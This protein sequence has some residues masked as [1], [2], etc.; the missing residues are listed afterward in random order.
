MSSGSTQSGIEELLKQVAAEEPKV[1]SVVE[2]KPEEKAEV[3]SVTADGEDIASILSSVE[4]EAP[5]VA[6]IASEGETDIEALLKQV[7]AEEPKVEA[8]VEAKPEEK[9]AVESVTAVGEDIASI[10]SSVEKEV[11]A[12]AATASE[13]ET[14]IEAL[15]KQ[16]AAEE[17]K[18]EAVVETK[19]E[20]KAVV[21][22]ATSGE[23]ASTNTSKEEEA[24]KTV[25]P[26]AGS[27]QSSLVKNEEQ[28]SIVQSISTKEFDISTDPDVI[29]MRARMK[30]KVQEI[31]KTYVN[32][33]TFSLSFILQMPKV[34]GRRRKV[35]QGLRTFSD[36]IE[37]EI[38]RIQAI[39]DPI[40]KAV[41][42]KSSIVFDQELLH[43]RKK[44][45]SWIRQGWRKSFLVGAWAISLIVGLSFGIPSVIRIYFPTPLRPAVS[46]EIALPEVILPEAPKKELGARSYLLLSCEESEMGKLGKIRVY[47]REGKAVAVFPANVNTMKKKVLT[48][49]PS[50]ELGVIIETEEFPILGTVELSPNQRRF[51]DL[52]KWTDVGARALARIESTPE[53]I[54]IACN[55]AWV[56]KGYATVYLIAGVHKIWAALPNFPA[57]EQQIM[58]IDDRDLELMVTVNMGR[59]IFN[60]SDQIK[61]MHPQLKIQVNGSPILNWG[62]YSLLFGYY[63]IKITDSGRTVLQQDLNL[64]AADEVVFKIQALEG[65]QLSAS[66]IS[67]RNLLKGD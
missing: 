21:E 27:E 58:V 50:G 33:K 31:L 11:P 28:S 60:V 22:K 49:V 44:G 12:V 24:G 51:I 36:W 46:K 2:T 39:E 26:I 4:K 57:Q 45:V 34:F 5:A 55:G 54:P 19:P 40:K 66:V 41:L 35:K 30:E 6:A 48:E 13:G 32:F 10:L 29:E 63:T 14:D 20:E 38:N 53:G 64:A 16:V 18:V 23:V 52:S 9:A 25:Y 65:N 67:K 7:A 62:S 42:V 8:V 37:T 43:V 15:L 59:L 47:D 56:G 61:K 17:P 3:E 1:E